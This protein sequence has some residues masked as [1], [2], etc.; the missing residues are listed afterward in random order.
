MTP[1]ALREF[2]LALPQATETFPFDEDNSVFKTS[3]NDRIF[4]ISH[5]A[6]KPLTIS[7]KCDPEDSIALRAEF[8]DIT[9]GYHLNKK[10][11]ITIVVGAGVPDDLVEDLIRGSHYLVR[12]GIP[13]ARVA[14]SIQ[15]TGQHHRGEY[16]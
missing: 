5:L 9:P 3:G 8:P 10:H 13:R 2:C 12:P 16:S 11:W 7:L 15:P 4:A 1:D 14:T 6:A